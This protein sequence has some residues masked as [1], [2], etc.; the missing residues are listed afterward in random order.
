MPDHYVRMRIRLTLTSR[1][2]DGVH[3]DPPELEL[4]W[5]L[6]LTDPP[7]S[8]HLPYNGQQQIHG[9]TSPLK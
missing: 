7:S 1:L 3:I 4:Q 5:N 9:V 8:G 2:E 6:P